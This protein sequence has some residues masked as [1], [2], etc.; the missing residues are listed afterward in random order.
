MTRSR[1]RNAKRN[2]V[3]GFINK[4]L[5]LLL[6]FISRTVIIRTIGIEYLGLGSL[7]SSILQVLSLAELGF[8]SA[9]VFSMYKPLE[10]KDTA[11]I[12]ALLSFYRRV[13]RIVGAVILVAGFA[14]MPF[15]PHLIHDAVPSDINLYWLYVIYLVST[16]FSYFGFAYKS[17]ILTAD[18]RQDIINNINTGLCVVVYI[19]QIALIVVFRNYYYY[20]GILI[21]STV[22]NNIIVAVVAKKWYPDYF[23]EGDLD[24]AEKKRITTQIK[25]LAIGKFAKTARNSLD[26]IVLSAFCGLVDVA[27]YNN[28]YYIF[29]A[30]LGFI[31]IILTSISAGVGNS[32][33]A[34][35]LDKNYADFKKFHFYI[36][37]IGSWCTICLLCLYQ[38]FREIWAGKDLKATD[39]VMVLF[40]VYFYI[41]QLGQTRAVYAASA[42]LWWEFRWLEIGEMLANLSL[43]I[44]LGYFLGM[45]GILLATIITVYLFSVVGVS[46]L[47]FRHFFKRKSREYHLA[48]LLNL[49]VTVF[50]GAVTYVLCSLFSVGNPIFLLAI[51]ALVCAAFPNLAFLALSRLNREYRGYVKAIKTIVKL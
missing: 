43:N 49:A 44:I 48:N 26:S 40:C 34:E 1:T 24:P 17:S 23:C 27:I 29:N 10:V 4:A 39:L 13:Y 42:G 47:T 46:N 2:M 38:P 11:A 30:I 18:Q 14:L 19:L 45:L 9:I 25:G 33:V 21:V 16:V 32:I 31:T 51:K 50:V 3:S 5:S 28:Y 37:W 35:S 15:L 36:S 8:S 12:R 7:F 6:P 20:A 22:A 41:T